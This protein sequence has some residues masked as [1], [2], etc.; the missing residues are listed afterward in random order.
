MKR[1]WPG[2]G[3]YEPINEGVKDKV[4]SYK[5]GSSVRTDIVSKEVV[6][7]PGPGHYTNEHDQFGKNG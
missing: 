4:R 6:S 2:P 1:K 5:M 3:Y 7:K